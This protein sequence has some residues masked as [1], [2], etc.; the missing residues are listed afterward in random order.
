MATPGP[1]RPVTVGAAR[2]NGPPTTPADVAGHR[3]AAEREGSAVRDDRWA[4]GRLFEGRRSHRRRGGLLIPSSVLVAVAV[5]V[6]VVALAVRFD[7]GRLSTAGPPPRPP[8][9]GDLPLAPTDDPLVVP[10]P[11]A[12]GR[13]PATPSATPSPSRGRERP[14]AASR[15]A[16][17]AADGTGP[18]LRIDRAAVPGTVD[19]TAEGRRDWVHWGH[20][21]VFSLERRDGG[22]FA[23]LEGTPTAPRH[24]HEASPQGFRWRGGAAPVVT[25]DG[26]RSGI[27]TCGAGNG[28]TVSA[29]AGEDTRTLRLYVGV[30][31]ARGTLTAALTGAP[32][33]RATLAAEGEDFAV[34]TLTYRTTRDARVRITWSTDQAF[35]IGC[36]GVALQAATL[37]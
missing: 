23:I 19:L 26:A 24:R 25:A 34:F 21:G 29:P 1:G 28:F 22:G 33:A 10:R 36:N 17:A 11:S 13:G 32:A 12:S 20:Q 5:V 6:A 16:A 18:V 31:Q 7:A 2:S 4:T 35:G 15:S 27:R 37:R 3:R 8:A 30:F 14:G 9:L